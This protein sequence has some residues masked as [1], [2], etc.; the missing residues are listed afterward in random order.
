[1]EK[2]KE[3]EKK[4]KEE[5]DAKFLNELLNQPKRASSQD[6]ERE[7]ELRVLKDEIKGDDR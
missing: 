7:N 5:E 4:V 2:Q 6:S 3:E 1:M